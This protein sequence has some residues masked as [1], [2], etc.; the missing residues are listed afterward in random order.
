MDMG[1]HAVHLLRSTLGPVT[2]AQATIG[3]ASGIYPDVDDNGIAL[4][5]F[6]NGALG[7]V[8]ASWV[9]TGGLGGGFEITGSG[10]TLF[11]DPAKGYLIASPGE[12]PKPVADGKAR[13]TQ[14]DR[15]VAAITGA[16]GKDELDA[17]LLCAVDA[18]AIMEACYE[19]NRTGAWVD[20]PTAG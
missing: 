4:L 19:S 18:V 17:D 6:A 8:E 14:V 13:P 15:L 9:Q 11:E 20:V 16:I 7:V 5:R 12:D 10:G 2:A 3:N 1:T